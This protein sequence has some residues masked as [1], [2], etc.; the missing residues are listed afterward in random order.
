MGVENDL[1][2]INGIGPKYAAL[3]KSV[4]VD[5]MK[6]LQHRNATNLLATLEEKNGGNLRGVDEDTVQSWIDEAKE[7]HH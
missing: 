6:E 4:G 2:D 3:L 5:S 7:I 1:A